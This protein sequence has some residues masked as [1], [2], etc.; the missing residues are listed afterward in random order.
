MKPYTLVVVDMQSGFQAANN[1]LTV[2]SVVKEV[3]RAIARNMPIIVLE[4]HPWENGKTH[5]EISSLVREY[6]NGYI[7]QKHR[8]SGFD[9][10][11]ET[12]NDN[13]LPNHFMV[14]GVNACFCVYETVEDLIDN[15]YPV[16]VVKTAVNGQKGGSYTG[17]YAIENCLTRLTRLGVVLL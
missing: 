16:E 8:N 6:D 5:R 14:V 15:G 4:L 9:E 10:L 13:G 17:K 12:V 7:V 1:P 2:T 11:M 3:K